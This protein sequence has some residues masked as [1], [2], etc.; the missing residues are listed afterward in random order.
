MFNQQQLVLTIFISSKL[1]NTMVSLPINFCTGPSEKCPAI[2]S[3][4]LYSVLVGFQII[5]TKKSFGIKLFSLETPYQIVNN[6]SNQFFYNRN[7][8]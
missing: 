1:I 2:F 5:D 8:E 7:E 6:V 3:D 4:H